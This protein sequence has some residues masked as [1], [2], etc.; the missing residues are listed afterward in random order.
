MCALICDVV[1]VGNMISFP[2]ELY[3]H[4]GG[5]FLVPYLL[6]QIFFGWPI[7]Y[8]ELSLGYY[9]RTTAPQLFRAIAPVAHAFGWAIVSE[10]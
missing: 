5:A 3:T 10:Q 2:E 8:L 4:G 6:A 1:G 9:A 7:V